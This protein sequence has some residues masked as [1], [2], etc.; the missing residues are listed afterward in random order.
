MEKCRFHVVRYCDVVK[1]K[2]NFWN[3]KFK[4]IMNDDVKIRQLQQKLREI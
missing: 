2:I 1:Y 3:N 4:V